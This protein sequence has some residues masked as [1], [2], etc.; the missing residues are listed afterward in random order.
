MKAFFAVLIFALFVAAAYAQSYGC[1]KLRVAEKT[2]QWYFETITYEDK[3]VFRILQ[4]GVTSLSG[5]E[6]DPLGDVFVEV[7]TATPGKEPKR[8][9]G[10]RTNST[11]RFY[12]SNIPQGSYKIRF[13]KDGGY[14]LTEYL[15]RVSPKSK[16]TTKIIGIIQVGK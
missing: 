5:S 14:E 15:V 4:G 3:K 2:R 8:I 12:F 6:K 10:C 7:F 13:S 11:G 1:V 16:R 9:A